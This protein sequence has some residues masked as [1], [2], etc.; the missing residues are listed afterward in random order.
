MDVPRL[1]GK[2]SKLQLPTTATTPQDLSCVCN[3][4]HSSRQC[5]VLTPLSKARD[6]THI[7]MNTSQVHCHWATRENCTGLLSWY[8]LFAPLFASPLEFL[9]V[10]QIYC[11][12]SHFLCVFYHAVSSTWTMPSSSSAL[13]FRGYTQ[14]YIPSPPS[15][16]LS[17]SS[18]F[19]R[20]HL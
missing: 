8:S 16:S 9:S 14:T 18:S 1:G 4:H 19:S 3:L 12:A 15:P 10:P 5:W 6:Q 11:V 13:P 2:S 7:L 20:S 17:N